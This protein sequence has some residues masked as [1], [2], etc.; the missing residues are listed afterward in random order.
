MHYMHYIQPFEAWHA[1]ST[2]DMSMEA[3]ST[4]ILG[5]YSY[6]SLILKNL[7]PIP[8]ILQPFQSPVTGSACDEIVSRA[9]NLAQE[10]NH[11][12][13]Q[14]AEDREHMHNAYLNGHRTKPSL[15]MGGDE[16]SPDK[17]RTSRDIRR[18]ADGRLSV[19]LGQRLRSISHRGR[20]HV[21]HSTPQ[22]DV[23]PYA[24]ITFPGVQYLLISPLAG[25]IA[26]LATPALANKFWGRKDETE[27]SVGKYPTL[28]VYGDQDIFTSAKKTRDWSQRLLELYGSTISSVEVAGAGHFWVEQGVE[29]ELRSSLRQWQATID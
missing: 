24:P 7:P 27:E 2:R 10:S 23:T 5:G 16:T 18:S 29:K 21:E 1:S 25:P 28:A 11:E 4:V 15:T 9:H 26:T 20:K 19:E 17:R 8:T 14:L 22:L 13:R 3:S 12:W 6:G